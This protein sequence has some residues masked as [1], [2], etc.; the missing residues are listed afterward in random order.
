MGR[1]QKQCQHC[2]AFVGPRAWACN[3]C[4]KGFV[5]QGELKPD[6]DVIAATQTH[7]DSQTKPLA[8]QRLWDLVIPCDDE[9]ERRFRKKYQSAGSSWIS[10]DGRY[11]I[12][13][14][15]TF[16]QVN[17]Q[18]HYTHCVYLLKYHGCEW[19]LVQPKGRCKTPLAAIKRMVL[20]INKSKP[21]AT[22]KEEKIQAK[23][24]LRQGRKSK[25]QL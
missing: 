13:E 5:I 3:V 23:I 2:G 22:T 10:K 11:R 14:Q 6:I 1:G 18:E 7:N 21:Q 8:K 16:M 25:L 19:C 9:I 12:R 20:D 4:G 24:K 15:N 17:M